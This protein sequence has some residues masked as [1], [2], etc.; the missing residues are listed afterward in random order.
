MSATNEVG[1][2]VPSHPQHA[3]YRALCERI[4]NIRS[5]G[6]PQHLTNRDRRLLREL[7]AERESLWGPLSDAAPPA[8]TQAD[9]VAGKPKKK[10]KKVRQRPAVAH[11][12]PTRRRARAARIEFQCSGCRKHCWTTGSPRTLCDDCSD[13]FR[14]RKPGQRRAQHGPTRLW[15]RL[16]PSGHPGSGVRH[17]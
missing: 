7:I 4:V 3:R 17:G 10:K 14:G 16:I 1:P 2:N 11:N 12:T 8:P 5:A 15:I 13:K 9:S 6:L